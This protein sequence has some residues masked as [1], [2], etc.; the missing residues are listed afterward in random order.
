MACRRK[1]LQFSE[2][3]FLPGAGAGDIGDQPL[4]VHRR[5]FQHGHQRIV[6]QKVRA[7]N[8]D[9]HARR[10]QL[11]LQPGLGISA[12]RTV[13]IRCSALDAKA[14]A[15]QLIDEP[16]VALLG[17]KEHNIE[18]RLKIFPA[19][20]KLIECLPILQHDPN[21]PEDVL[22]VDIDDDGTGGDDAYDAARYGLMARCRTWDVQEFRR[23]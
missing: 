19:C 13:E 18:A 3:A 16:A 7:D 11:R 6:E 15:G 20:E 21:R 8:D 4:A 5:V 12:G 23:F 9:D 17:D 14:V 22:K 2:E 1:R 10:P